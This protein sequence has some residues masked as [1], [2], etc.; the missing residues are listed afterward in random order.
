[1]NA[2]RPAE[3]IRQ[4]DHPQVPDREL[5]TRFVSERDQAAFATLVRRHGPI[6]LGVC[7]RVTGHHQDAEDAFQASFLILARKASRL[8]QPDLLGNWLYGVALRVAQK[9]RRA[10]QRRRAREIVMCAVP[11][12]A[13]G[14]E[15]M[16]DELR[17]VLDEE[18]SALPSWYRDAIILC[19]LRGFS[20][21]EAAA[22]MHIPEGTLSSRLAKGRKKL[23][24]RLSQRGIALSV[25][26]AGT[27]GM[28]PLSQPVVAATLL[29]K[30]CGLVADWLAGATA[31][32]PITR[33]ADGGF[34]MRKVVVL[35]LFTA[36]AALAGSILA[37]Q[38]EKPNPVPDAP[39]PLVLTT[40]QGPEDQKVA[41]SKPGEK[42]LAF[43][44]TPRMVDAT[45]ID[46]PY[47]S[48]NFN[49]CWSPDG[50]FL[51]VGGSYPEAGQP[52]KLK[53]IV[54][55]VNSSSPA[56]QQTLKNV[57]SQST[58]IGF[59]PDGKNVLT[60]IHERHLLSGFHKLDFWATEVLTDQQLQERKEPKNGR[61]R[62]I[63]RSINVDPKDSSGYIFSPDGKRF[64]TV[65]FEREARS[66]EV[67]KLQV[68]EVDAGTGK[69]IKSLMSFNSS[70]YVLFS[71]DGK[72]LALVEK[73][74]TIVIYD[75]DRGKKVSSYSI[76]GD[77]KTPVTANDFKMTNAVW[78]NSSE[79][80]GLSM[81]FSPDGGR[82]AISRGLGRTM[83]LLRLQEADQDHQLLLSGG[84]G[85]IVVLNVETGKPMPALEGGEFLV[86]EPLPGGNSFTGGGRL[87]VI[88]GTRY[89]HHKEKLR[90][91]KDPDREFSIVRSDGR[92][93]T[94]WDT[95]TGKVIKTWPNR[96]Q[97]VAFNP[98]RPVLAMLEPN[99]ESTRVGFWDFRAEIPEKK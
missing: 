1:M 47:S 22:A 67:G 33:L 88:S 53:S 44:G 62:I 84:T 92:F 57:P 16:L 63:E 18:L 54:K 21:E 96:S 24:A 68:W 35:G 87:L 56:A 26:G 28:F 98:V 69:R 65:A 89:T 40:E 3:L 7:E 90:H 58:L 10:A 38:P 45:D 9:A 51:A 34:A 73:E 75:V 8:G 36:V 43:T 95:E 70:P 37:S 27:C 66:D 50:A 42:P 6:V 55:V 4:L 74:N 14:R 5:L 64:R 79:E 39:K 46:I 48:V 60:E 12:I 80:S 81:A 59:T 41:D 23:A 13:R 19:D 82:L 49:V 91:A 2:G 78:D 99:G 71:P 72:R 30:T 29:E 86:P 97:Y 94:V 25:G 85:Q 20:R 52:Q 83:Q 93:I 61:W 11:E 17:P 15:P 31:P 76:P 32:K 77:L